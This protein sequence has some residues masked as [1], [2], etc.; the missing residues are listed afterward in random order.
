[1]V[2]RYIA[3]PLLL[4]LL[5]ACARTGSVSVSAR[6]PESGNVLVKPL[7]GV[8]SDAPV[9]AWWTLY[10][11]PVLV[12]V[13]DDALRDNLDIR[14]AAARVA[15]ARSVIDESR[16]ARLPS[17]S[18]TAGAGYGST[19]ADQVG[20]ALNDTP[21]RTGM[22]YDAGL[23][24]AWDTDIQGRQSA[25]IRAARASAAETQ[26]H[27]DGVR[28]DVAAE[29]ARAYIDICAFAV[30]ATD[31][32]RSLDLLSR[33]AALHAKMRAIGA[34]NQLD[35]VRTQAL[36]EEAAAAIPPLQAAHDNA[37]Y[38]LALLM[39]TSATTLPDDVT[40]CH[41]VPRL[42]SP[43]PTGDIAGLLR[44]RPD[45]RA[46]DERL[47]VST[48]GIDVATSQLYP[49]ISLGA[50]LLSSAPTIGGLDQRSSTVWRVGPLLSWSFPNLSVAR[51]RIAGAH[52]DQQ[53]TLALFDKTILHAIADVRMALTSYAAAQQHYAALQ[54][55]SDQASEALRLAQI[56]HSLGA[57]TAI[58]L[59]DAER[60]DVAARQA[61]SASH[62]DVAVAQ[63]GLFRA[64][65][66]GW[67]RA[68]T[69]ASILLSGTS[70]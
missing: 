25:T 7:N 12:R 5:G 19:L 67:Q 42:T 15:Q 36:A 51:A 29:A 61:V 8:S 3:F 55:A 70:H 65:G 41:A 30:R 49:S 46:A 40:S 54:R 57:S 68:D 17:T 62:A 10:D 43:L 69:T 26:A 66:G 13:V 1:M 27:A 53:A 18:V 20:A 64:L 47:K 48:A 24:F 32:Q 28:I 9:D 50:G 11:D 23:D 34:G 58:D 33:S 16:R 2:R 44:R 39:G 6:T 4:L 37:I 60:S 21:I 59:L 35:V 45:V 22:R 31:A 63:V 52:A 14:V 56:G 38:E